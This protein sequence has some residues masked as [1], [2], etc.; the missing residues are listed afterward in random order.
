MR[1]YRAESPEKA[2]KR[3]RSIKS[4]DTA[5]EIVLRRAL[6]R[7]GLRYRLH[8]RDLPGNPDIVVAGKRTVIFVDGD[9]W[10]G[11]LLRE[12][13]PKAL[14]ATF[15]GERADYWTK[16]ITTN[17]SRDDQ[18]NQLLLEAGWTVIRVW[19]TDIMR[20]TP[21]LATMLFDY[22]R[23][24]TQTSLGGLVDQRTIADALA[25]PPSALLVDV[26]KPIALDT[27]SYVRA[28]MPDAGSG[29]AVCRQSP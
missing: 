10:H 16:R 8:R 27:E 21:S 24:R 25:K 1:A 22:I 17:T 11:R 12:E 5:P 23:S 6:W 20:S 9:F 4:C 14:R 28:K 19:Q 2:S 26:C 18:I 3:M 7:L 13:G 29:V 15:R